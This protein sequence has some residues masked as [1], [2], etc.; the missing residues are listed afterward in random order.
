MIMNE[1]TKLIFAALIA[2]NPNATVKDLKV[3]LDDC[4]GV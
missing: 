3:F 2:V 1:V 4:K